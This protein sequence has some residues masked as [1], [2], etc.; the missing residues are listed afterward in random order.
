[1][2]RMT[3]RLAG[4]IAGRLKGEKARKSTM[5]WMDKTGLGQLLGIAGDAAI[6]GGALK[7]ASALKGLIT[8]GGGGAAGAITPS[9]T[10]PVEPTSLPPIAGGGAPTPIA[11][12]VSAS[13]NAPTGGMSL[14]PIAGGGAPTPI[15]G[16]V[17]A[18]LRAPA[19]GS[20][21][22]PSAGGASTPIASQVASAARPI[23]GAPTPMAQQLSASMAPPAATSPAMGALAKPPMTASVAERVVQPPSTGIGVPKI[24]PRD[25]VP[26]DIPAPTMMQKVLGAVREAPG[27]IGRFAKENKEAVAYG[28][29]AVMQSLSASQQAALEEEQMRMEQERRNRLAQ[30]LMPLFESEVKRY[31]QSRRG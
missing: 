24:T 11:S 1:M 16:Q 13:L 29:P 12:Q 22:L 30:L 7:G 31:G 19:A 21:G 20:M 14:P 25:I 3:S 9:L 18:G 27:A 8:G 5:N 26:T 2:A 10:A 23:A 4:W 17:S 6:V 15:A 28:V